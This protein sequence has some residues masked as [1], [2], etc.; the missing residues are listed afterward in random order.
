MYQFNIICLSRNNLFHAPNYQNNTQAKGELIRTDAS[1][2]H[3]KNILQLD[4][5]D[6]N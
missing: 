4:Y 1:K 2:Q 5:L 6:S 3:R